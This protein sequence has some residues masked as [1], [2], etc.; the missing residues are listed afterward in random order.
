MAKAKTATTAPAKAEKPV[1][2]KAAKA[3]KAKKAPKAEGEKVKRA[4]SAFI[5]YSNEHREAIKK[6]NPTAT[7]GEIGKLLGAQWSGLDEK[8]KAVS[9]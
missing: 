2:A 8:A 7:F 9:V 4:P 5:I 6:A 1:A 3:T